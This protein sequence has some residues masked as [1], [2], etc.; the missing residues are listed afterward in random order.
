MHIIF[1]AWKSNSNHDSSDRRNISTIIDK[2][3]RE[4]PNNYINNT[5][6]QPKQTKQKYLKKIKNLKSRVV[7]VN[8]WSL[9]TFLIDDPPLKILYL[10]KLAK[11]NR[12]QIFWL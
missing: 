6:Y 2:G 5:Y 10:K 7:S 1:L 4:S 9:C 11:F 8:S 12:E 3:I